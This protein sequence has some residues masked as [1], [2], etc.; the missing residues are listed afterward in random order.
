MNLAYKINS[1][2]K[3]YKHFLNF[4]LE[5][6]EEENKS[7]ELSDQIDLTNRIN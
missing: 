7:S 6:D 4:Y 1:I 5:Y 2:I 3:S